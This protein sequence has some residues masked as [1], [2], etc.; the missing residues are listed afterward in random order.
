MQWLIT[1]MLHLSTWSMIDWLKN[2]FSEIFIIQSK[3]YLR[4]EI[5]WHWFSFS[6]QKACRL[7][8]N[9]FLVIIW[10][11]PFATKILFIYYIIK[12]V[13]LNYY[14]G[15][16]S[17]T[18]TLVRGKIQNYTTSIC[19]MNIKVKEKKK[20]GSKLQHRVMC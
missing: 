8:K 14:Y 18:A 17:F 1:L 16:S 13:K 4:S 2:T 20:I 12:Y 10:Y 15:L 19:I 7:K 11:I 6:T 9:E 3:W 5:I